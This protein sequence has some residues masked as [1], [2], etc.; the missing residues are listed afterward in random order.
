MGKLRLVFNSQNSLKLGTFTS[1]LVASVFGCTGPLLIVINAANKML[2]STE[3]TVSWIFSIY[4]FGGLL[5]VILSLKYKMPISGAYS[6]A[7][8]AMILNSG[9]IYQFEEMIF[10]YL[11]SGLIIFL[12][13]ISGFKENII[14]HIPLPIVMGMIAGVLTKF[15]INMV[16]TISNNLIMGGII[17]ISY[18]IAMRFAPKIPPIILAFLSGIAYVVLSN[19][20]SISSVSLDWM[21]PAIYIPKIS[22]DVIF[23]ISVPLSILILGSENTQAIGVLIAQGYK[24]PINSMTIFSGIASMVA[25][26]FGGHAANIAGPMTAICAS[27]ESSLNKNDRYMASVVNGIIYLVFGIF[28]SVSISLINSIPNSVVIILAGLSLISVIMKAYNSSFCS[29]N[30]KLGSIFAFFIALSDLKFYGITS[31]IFALLVGV[32]VSSIV[33]SSDFKQT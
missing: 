17:L 21:M 9:Q 5:G 28:A 10:G 15:S 18:F 30:F 4:F 27:P 32:V 26:F 16:T 22:F 29:P 12:V 20:F 11:I 7:G 24:P 8:A 14:R 3:Q 33:E 1:G 13:G 25:S 19:E 2:L 31:P 23:V 6:I